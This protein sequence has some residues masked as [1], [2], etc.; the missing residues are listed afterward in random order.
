M[1][2]HSYTGFWRDLYCAVWLGEKRCA[3]PRVCV[4]GLPFDVDLMGE[5][6]LCGSQLQ[7]V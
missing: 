6:P 4:R 7:V 3:E 2:G 5:N 1:Q